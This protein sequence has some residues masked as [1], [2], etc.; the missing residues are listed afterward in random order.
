MRSAVYHT[1]ALSICDISCGFW[2][3]DQTIVSFLLWILLNEAWIHRV[4]LRL[5]LSVQHILQYSGRKPNPTIK[6]QNDTKIITLDKCKLNLIGIT[7]WTIW[8]CFFGLHC[9]RVTSGATLADLLVASM[10]AKSFWST[11]LHMWG[12]IGG[13]PTRERVCCVCLT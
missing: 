10:V 8:A 11:H 2:D 7:V 5:S 6:Y 3:G 13:T 9:L 1:P 12:G 4:P